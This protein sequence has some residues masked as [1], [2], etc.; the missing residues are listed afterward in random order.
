MC[1]HSCE[2]KSNYFFLLRK[3]SATRSATRRAQNSHM[4]TR[5]D[6]SVFTKALE[7]ALCCCSE[8]PVPAA[9]KAHEA[10]TRRPNEASE[11]AA[12]P[13]VAPQPAELDAETVAKLAAV[14]ERRQKEARARREAERA[15]Q[16]T[17]QLAARREAALLSPSENPVLSQTHGWR[18]LALQH[19]G[20]DEGGELGAGA[21][22]P[23]GGA[24][25]MHHNAH[26]HLFGW[27]FVRSGRAGRAHRGTPA[28]CDDR[29]E[30]LSHL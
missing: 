3:G 13:A 2:P 14:R 30:E 5:T 24:L 1:A 7:L 22:A 23:R 21:V 4:T 10:P 6:K 18:R 16:T 17:L 28:R 25:G 11:L 15:A 12:A 29:Q 20:A 27:D 8:I 9:V 26:A 19:V